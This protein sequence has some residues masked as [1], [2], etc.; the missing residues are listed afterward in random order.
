MDEP[1]VVALS[2][3]LRD[4]SYTRVAL[5]HALEAAA[6][7]GATTGCVDLRDLE[8]PVFD[9]DDREA[10][11]AAELLARVERADSLLLGTPVYHGSYSGVLKNAIDYCGFEEFR[12]TTCGLVAV[13]GGGLPGGTFAHLRAVCSTLNAWVIP[14]TTAIPRASDR[15][16]RSAGEVTDPSIADRLAQLGENAVRYAG[17]ES[18][19]R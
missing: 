11:D 10:G 7:R 2:G 16:D 17:I 13:S 6:D 3:S 1:H 19:E 4:G 12:D 18:P 15:I 5:D 9:A 8:L 14:R